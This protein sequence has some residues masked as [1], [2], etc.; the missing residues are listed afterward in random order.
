MT[1]AETPLKF[2][3]QFPIKA[4]GE[5]QDDFVAHV[6]SLVS[7]HVKALPDDAI[8]TRDSGGGRFTAVTVTIEATSRE[9]LDAIYRD[10]SAS[11]RIKFAL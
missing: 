11:D 1:S 6:R 4:I 3:C 5:S 9:Q 10:L 7:R 2:P 8:Q